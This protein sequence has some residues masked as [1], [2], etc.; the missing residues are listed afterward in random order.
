MAPV[1]GTNCSVLTENMKWSC[2]QTTFF[3]QSY[4]LVPCMCVCVRMHETASFMKRF[5]E[6]RCA[7]HVYG[8]VQECYRNET[9]KPG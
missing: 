1:G 6:K 3:Q 7:Y 8:N 4:L 9:R 2:I 5:L